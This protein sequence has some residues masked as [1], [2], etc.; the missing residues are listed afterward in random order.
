M[1]G[2]VGW[3]SSPAEI[4]VTEV[5]WARLSRGAKLPKSISTYPTVGSLESFEEGMAMA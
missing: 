1:N 3:D 2:L 5:D 4:A